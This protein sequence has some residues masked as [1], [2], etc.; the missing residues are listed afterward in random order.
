MS[1]DDITAP[2]LTLVPETPEV[3]KERMSS[4]RVYSVPGDNTSTRYDF[5]I[6][7]LDGTEGVRPILHW[8]QQTEKLRLA[9]NHVL[10]ATMDAWN[11]VLLTLLHNPAK[12]SYEQ[13]LVTA[14]LNAWEAA[15]QLDY[16]NQ[17][18]LNAQDANNPTAAEMAA[19]QAHSAGI[20][21]PDLAHFTIL[22]MLSCQSL[23]KQTGHILPTGSST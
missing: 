13:K 22:A 12:S 8:M 20:P 1:T 3:E 5:P 4:F 17:I 9:S 19:A 14:K 23:S 16:A 7:Q 11:N 10:P 15:R 2:L 21:E 18:T 6:A